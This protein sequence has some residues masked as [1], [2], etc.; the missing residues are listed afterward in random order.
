MNTDSAAAFFGSCALSGQP[1]QGASHM[2]SLVSRNSLLDDF[3]RDFTPG[4]FV[5]PL[6]GDNLPAQIK[7]DVKEVEGGYTVNAEIPGV[8]KDDIHVGI[9]GNVIT[10]RAEVKQED[11]KTEGEKVLRSERYYGAVS[12][13]FQLPAEIDPSAAKAKYE[14]GVLALTL[15]RKSGPSVKRLTVE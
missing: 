3:F 11:K 1:K 14:N 12:R 6:H 4:Y 5:K 10:L 15:P 9:D 13:S 8:N 2:N 7:V